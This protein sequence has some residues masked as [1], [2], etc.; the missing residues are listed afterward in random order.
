MS[1]K[2]RRK[3]RRGAQGW[4]GPAARR[5]SA[6]PADGKRAARAPRA[7]APRR[8]RGWSGGAKTAAAVALA[9]AAL[10]AIYVLNRP[11][12]SPAGGAY[13]FQVGS[14]GPG[15]QAPPITLPSTDGGTFDLGSMQGK[16]VLL[17]FQ[18]GLMCQPCW[19]QLR[20]IEAEFERFRELGIDEVVTITTDPLDALAQK[21]ADEGL[22]TPVLSDPDLAVS[23]A[24]DTNSYGMMGN[25]RNGHSFIVVGPDGVIRWRADYGGAPDYTMYV[26]VDSLLADMRQ[27]LEEAS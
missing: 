1:G 10:G 27:G 5:A 4:S 20:D 26:P 9:V 11:G 15:E 7:R 12:G 6:A 17:Y 13:A 8:R 3:S 2:T 25:S 14:P 24:Y 16:T 19:D 23:Q 21:V 22:T 18:E